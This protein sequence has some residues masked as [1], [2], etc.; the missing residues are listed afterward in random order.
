MLSR[1]L[2]RRGFANFAL[3][4]FKPGSETHARMGM[5]LDKAAEA[6]N[7]LVAPYH[8]YLPVDIMQTAMIHFEEFIPLG[9][10]PLA[11]VVTAVAVRCLLFPLQIWSMKRGAEHFHVSKKLG[12]IMD[13][14]QVATRERDHKRATQLASDYRDLSEK[15][16]KFFPVKG[17]L[18]GAAIGVNYLTGLYATLGLSAH[19]NVFNG[20]ALSSPLWLDSLCLPDPLYIL[21]IASTAVFLTNL[22][23]SGK[24]DSGATSANSVAKSVMKKEA[25]DAVNN[26]V[27]PET[28]AKLARNGK[29]MLPVCALYFTTGFPSGYFFFMLPMSIMSVTQNHLLRQPKIRTYL[30]LDAF[31]EKQE[32]VKVTS[33]EL[34]SY[35]DHLKQ[36]QLE[37]Q[38]NQ[39]A[40]QFNK[41]IKD[42]ES[43]ESK[44]SFEVARTS[45]VAARKVPVTFEEIL[46]KARLGNI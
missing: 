29:R 16:G 32:S 7:D 15:Y 45:F 44:E 22:E 41:V 13:D 8:P 30:G 5:C 20:F 39:V 27:S 19:P 36:L 4:P 18:G 2:P 10:W 17:L 23:L 25:E 38:L 40:R 26:F 14:M 12:G 28:Q 34:V 1:L 33:D 31:D 35:D 42:P 9:G 6:G 21:P 43:S 24:F 3:N 37:S 11:M 46:A